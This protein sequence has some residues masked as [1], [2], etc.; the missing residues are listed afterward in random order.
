MVTDVND[1][2]IT[3]PNGYNLEQNHPNPFNP[4]T[5]INFSLANESKVTLKVFGMLGNEIATLVD[6]NKNVGIHQVNFDASGLAGGLYCYRLTTENFSQ[7][8]KMLLLK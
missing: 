7:T 5:V 2:S 1:E 6:E 8:K 3:A 4:S